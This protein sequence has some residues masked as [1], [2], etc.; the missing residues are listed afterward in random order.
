MIVGEFRLR[1]RYISIWAVQA[2]LRGCG[3]YKPIHLPNPYRNTNTKWYRLPVGQEV[4]PRTMQTLEKVGIT[5]PAHCPYSSP[6]W[7]T[8]KPDGT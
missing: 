2:I 6:V 7:P 1:E 5:R 3:E 8:Q 4:I